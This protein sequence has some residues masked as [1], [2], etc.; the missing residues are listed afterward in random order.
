MIYLCRLF[1]YNICSMV[2]DNQL[3]D[4]YLRMMFSLKYIFGNTYYQHS[5]YHMYKSVLK[6]LRIHYASFIIGYYDLS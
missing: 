2:H 6:I 5:F 3:I 1:H 4:I